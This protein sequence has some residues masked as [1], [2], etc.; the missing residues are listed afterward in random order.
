MTGT[1]NTGVWKF[2]FPVGPVRRRRPEVAGWRRH[3]DCCSRCGLGPR[4]TPAYCSGWSQV[5]ELLLGISGLGIET[6]STTRGSL[7][8]AAHN[9]RGRSGRKRRDGRDK[10]YVI[11]VSPLQSDCEPC[12]TPIELQTQLGQSTDVLPFNLHLLHT[13]ITIPLS[14]TGPLHNGGA[15]TTAH[16]HLVIHFM[17]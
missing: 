5:T 10:Q 14:A 16:A 11:V 4:V 9:R 2:K 7:S 6:F 12:D 8:L 17:S 15:R 3:H 13:P 1:R